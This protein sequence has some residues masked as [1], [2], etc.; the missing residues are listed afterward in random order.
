MI[1]ALKQIIARY[2]GDPAWNRLRP[3]LVE[4]SAE[5]ARGLLDGLRERGFAMPGLGAAR[6]AAD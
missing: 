1:P 4:L 5:Q 6:G 2:S 3:P